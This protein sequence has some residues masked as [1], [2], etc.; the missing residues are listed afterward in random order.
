MSVATYPRCANAWMLYSESSPRSSG[1][2]PSSAWVSSEMN[3]EVEEK[4]SV[5][6]YF[7]DCGPACQDLIDESPQGDEVAPNVHFLGHYGVTSVA[8]LKAPAL[9]LVSHLRQ[10]QASQDLY[11]Q[12]LHPELAP[13]PSTS[14]VCASVVLLLALSAM[15]LNVVCAWLRNDLRVHDSPVLSR[16]AQLSREQKLP[17]LP[18]YLFDPRQ[19][20]ETKFGTLKTGAFRALFLLQSV[21]VLKRKL[22]SMGSDLLVKVGKPEDVLPSLLDKQ[23]V[24]VTQEE[25][26]SEERSVDRALRRELATKGCEAWEYCW[27]STLFHRDDLP[28]QKDLSNAPD[29]FTSFKNQV[30]PEMAARVNEVPTSFQDKRKDKSHMGVRR[31]GVG[32]GEAQQSYGIRI[33]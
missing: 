8:G 12:K 31:R 21:R 20:R 11:L 25:V 29:V 5:P 32:W 13:G 17:V 4:P 16:A 1:F 7:I 28:F 9:M 6:I 23:S 30:E 19:L 27:G 26:T 24:L 22:R 15:A 14:S 2:V 10:M 18:V 33:I 3:L